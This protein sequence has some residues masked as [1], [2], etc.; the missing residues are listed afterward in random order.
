MKTLVYV[1]GFNLYFGALRSTPYKG[2]DVWE[3]VRMH[4]ASHHR[5]VGLKYYT[6]RMQ[7]RAN[8]PDQP[9]RQGL[10]LR[11][12]STRPG[13][14][15]FL[16]HF[17]KKMIRMPLAHPSPGGPATVEVIKTEEK[18]SDVNLA[19]HLLNDAH[20]QRFDCAVVVS[21]DSDLLEPVRLVMTGLGKPVGVLNPQKYPCTVLKKQATFYKHLRPSLLR[22]AVFPGELA[23]NQGTFHKPDGW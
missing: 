1:D 5:I 22:R 2:L 7:P 11:A 19:T 4:L 8:D 14:E 15:I 20:L 6:A 17:L 21:G 9:L 23:D 16:G 10:Y 18:G 3:A 12:L 13:T